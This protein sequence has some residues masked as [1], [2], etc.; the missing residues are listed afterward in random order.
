[1]AIQMQGKKTVEQEFTGDGYS[2]R[3]GFL[4][5]VSDKK[6]LSSGKG[7]LFMIDEVVDENGD[8]NPRADGK[9][10]LECSLEP[11][12]GETF[13]NGVTG[14]QVLECMLEI[15]DNLRLG[16]YTDIYGQSDDEAGLT[17]V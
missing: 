13:E 6:S 4:S 1:M 14:I 3:L 11:I 12:L 15:S 10:Q 8:F 17:G 2:C 16:N 5:L 7:R 9:Y